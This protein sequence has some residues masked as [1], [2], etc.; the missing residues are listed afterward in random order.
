MNTF[1]LARSVRLAIAG[2]AAITLAAC[3][4]PPPNG[5]YAE[6]GYYP[7]NRYDAPQ[8][9]EYLEIDG[10]WQFR[11]SKGR[12]RT[13]RI[14]RLNPD[15]MLASPVGRGGRK[16]QYRKV[17]LGLYRDMDGSGTYEFTSRDRAIWRSNTQ[18]PQVLELRRI[19]YRC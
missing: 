5:T 8:E 15:S 19:G 17:R 1:P 4:M 11:D 12:V 3:V 2:F 9:P 13:N 7:D 10:C 16:A 18:R 14:E 6:G